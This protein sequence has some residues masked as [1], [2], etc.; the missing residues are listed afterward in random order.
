MAKPVECVCFKLGRVDPR[1]YNYQPKIEVA[2]WSFTKAM[3]SL[4][5]DDSNMPL[6]AS[7][8]GQV[9]VEPTTHAKGQ[10]G[11]DAEHPP[12]RTYAEEQDVPYMDENDNSLLASTAHLKVL[13]D[14]SNMPS[15]VRTVRTSE[16]K[17]P[18]STKI[19]IMAKLPTMKMM[20]MHS[21][22][23][24]VLSNCFP[25]LLARL[26]QMAVTRCDGRRCICKSNSW[27]SSSAMH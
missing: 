15:V 4:V 26:P 7:H 17:G 3:E 1:G 8:H 27:P 16:M 2:A 14:D 20:W 23:L 5:V 11:E 10:D 24:L 9:Q 6:L 18:P 22:R 25:L 19:R 12:F 13:T 21:I